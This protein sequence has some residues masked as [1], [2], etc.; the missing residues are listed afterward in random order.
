MHPICSDKNKMITYYYCKY[1]Q[2]CYLTEKSDARYRKRIDRGDVCE[3]KAIACP[4]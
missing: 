3:D 4:C 1:N 2:M